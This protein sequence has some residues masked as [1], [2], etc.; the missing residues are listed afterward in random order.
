MKT[1]SFDLDDSQASAQQVLGKVGKSHI[2]EN[3]ERTSDCSSE[4]S[5]EGLNEANQQISSDDILR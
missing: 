1:V 3:L 5:H 2:E 4:E